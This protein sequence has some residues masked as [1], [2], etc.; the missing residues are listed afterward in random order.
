MRWAAASMSP[1]WSGVGDPQQVAELAL[2]VAAIG[3]ARR[4]RVA[5][6][7]HAERPLHRVAE[8]GGGPV[9]TPVEAR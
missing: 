1:P 5:E 2:D 7:Q 3:D 9:P 6:V 4:T 8:G